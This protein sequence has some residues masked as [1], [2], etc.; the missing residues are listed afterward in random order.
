MITKT[1]MIL[2]LIPR[3]DL[4]NTLVKN[5]TKSEIQD[6]GNSIL[7]NLIKTK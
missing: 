1:I 3:A 2:I 5:S 7:K 6:I 4:T